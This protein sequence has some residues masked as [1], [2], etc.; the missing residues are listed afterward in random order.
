MSRG[1]HAHDESVHDDGYPVHT[2]GLD[3]DTDGL[4]S[5]QVSVAGL[6][7]KSIRLETVISK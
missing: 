1:V 2:R 6:H 4:E 3:G 5:R 7:K